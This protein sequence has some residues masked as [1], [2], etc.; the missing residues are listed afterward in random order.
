MHTHATPA[1]HLANFDHLPGSAYL[2]QA[3]ITGTQDKAG[4]L[5]FSGSTLWRMVKAGKFPAPIKFGPKTTAWKVA[6]LRSWL[7]Q[8]EAANQ[9]PQAQ[10][11]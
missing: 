5:P 3:D 6:D 1:A 8:Q 10:A 7:A 9:Q 11:Q 4:L 2:R